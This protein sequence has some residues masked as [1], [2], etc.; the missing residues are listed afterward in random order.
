MLFRFVNVSRLY[1]YKRYAT[2]NDETLHEYARINHYVLTT[3]LR[4]GDNLWYMF[5]PPD[6][7]WLEVYLAHTVRS[8]AI[9][10]LREAGTPGM[11]I[12]RHMMLQYKSR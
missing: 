1:D 3:E 10:L 6:R 5:P 9:T 4:Q 8:M 2:I 11:H 12:P 7:Q